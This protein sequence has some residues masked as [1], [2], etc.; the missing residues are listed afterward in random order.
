MRFAVIGAASGFLAVAFGAFGA[1][2][3]EKRLAPNLLE[4]FEIAVRYQMY[5]ALALFAVA[6]FCERGARVARWSG[7]AFTAGTLL[8]SGSL[9]AYVLSEQ[10]A[11]ALITPIGG[12]CF[13]LGWVLLASAAWHSRER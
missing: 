11:F 3:L 12:T 10:R 1:H 2:A 8:F 7:M 5:H 4:T 9:Y 6:W 13:L